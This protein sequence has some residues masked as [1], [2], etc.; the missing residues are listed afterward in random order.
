MMK[1]KVYQANIEWK[2]KFRDYDF[3]M[4][5]GGIEEDQ[6]GCCYTG[7]LD[8]NDLEEV[9]FILNMNHPIGFHGHSLSTGDIIKVEGLGT[10][11][12]DYVGFVEIFDFKEDK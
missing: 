4:S 11:F 10:Y 3:V 1:V 9:F 7:F 12:V 5:H 8:A 2:N 6:Y